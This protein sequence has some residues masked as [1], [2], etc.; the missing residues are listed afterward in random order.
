MIE[1]HGGRLVD[2]R[3]NGK[4]ADQIRE[5]ITATPAITLDWSH[6]QDLVNIG[7][8]RFS[9]LEGFLTRNDF[10]KVVHDMTLE[11]GTVWSLPITLDVDTETAE[12]LVPGEMAGLR[13]P[14]G[15]LA[16]A[17][18]IAELYR[19]NTSDAAGSLYGTDGD[20]HPGVQAFRSKDQFFVG[21]PVVL[22]GDHRHSDYDL[23]PAESRVLF[24]H[25]GWETV[26]GFQ[27]RN[28]P[29]RAHEYIQR[30]ALEHID[31]LLVQPKVGNK[32]V[33]DYRDET[34][35]QAYNEL[36][37]NYY[38]PDR[39][40][41]SVFPSK[42]RYAGPREAVYDAIVRKN[43]GCSHFIIGRDHAGVGS[44]Y[45]EFDAQRI[46]DSIGDIGIEV[47]RYDYAFFC[48]KCD[49]MTSE[50]ICPHDAD[51][52]IHPSGTGIRRKIRNGERP[53]S[54]IMR[55]EVADYIIHADQPFVGES[56]A[57][58]DTQ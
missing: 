27:T 8:G 42:M 48:R 33:D 29:H 9:P 22:F 1:P 38:H 5:E 49:A 56:L 54:K 16:G 26:A 47:L 4:H 31:G 11:D 53:S 15:T 41:L 3:V 18:E 39:F 34:I 58:E 51:Q 30:S 19:A 40:V 52:Q 24:R 37:A 17:I 57:T 20:D 35:I 10:L 14:D 44:Y 23:L 43:Q 12:G 21:G 25:R 36:V 32:K 45:G 50:S 7:T 28:A 46:F 55:P 13:A 6:Y 2:R